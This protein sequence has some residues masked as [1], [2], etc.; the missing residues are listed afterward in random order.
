MKVSKSYRFNVLSLL[1][2]LMELLTPGKSVIKRGSGR[3][4]AADDH[5]EDKLRRYPMNATSIGWDCAG[6]VAI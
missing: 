2:T 1:L 5:G 6:G 3:L 4:A